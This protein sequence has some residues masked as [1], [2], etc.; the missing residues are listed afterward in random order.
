M[1]ETMAAV[2]RDKQYEDWRLFQ[3]AFIL[4]NLASFVTRETVYAR[5]YDEQRDDTVTLL[6]FATGGG[7]S[8][9]FLGLLTFLLFFDRL[10][11]KSRG[12][13][14]L[15]RYPLRLLTIQQAQRTAKVLAKAERIRRE[16]RYSGAAFEIGFWVGR[17][18]S[19]N[20]LRDRSLRDIP[21]LDQVAI[22]AEAQHR[23]DNRRY[24]AAFKAWSKLPYCPFCNA[25]TALRRMS[26]HHGPVAHVCTSISCF[27]NDGTYV[28]LPFY[29]CDEDIYAIAPSV[30]LGTVDK[31]ALI[32][33]SPRTIRRILGM[34]GAAPWVHQGT[35]RL[36]VPSPRDLQAGPAAAEC[37]AISPAY[38]S[39]YPFFMTHFRR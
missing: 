23:R 34:L 2:A 27:A 25:P 18:G 13:S 35:G 15:L 33:H 7:K 3:L 16:R 29:I 9:A 10:R 31:L 26:D 14:A 20:S 39:G 37:Q 1:N 6:Y 4:A 38:P 22:D 19:P 32:G 30:L 24:A 21:R 12:V 28:Q 5:W 8:E 11:G 36:V 17:S